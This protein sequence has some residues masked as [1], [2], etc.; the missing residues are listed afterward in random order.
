MPVEAVLRRYI[1]K[2]GSKTSVYQKYFIEGRRNIYGIDFPE[3]LAANQELPM[4]TIITP[5]TKEDR[6]GM[7]DEELKDEEAEEVTDAKCGKG[8]LGKSKRSN[9]CYF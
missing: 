2:T 5:T 7:H 6:P 9:P 1:A 8:T 3:G 4:G